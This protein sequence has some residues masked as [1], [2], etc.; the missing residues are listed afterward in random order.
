MMMRGVRTLVWVGCC[1][2]I[3]LGLVAGGAGARRLSVGPRGFRL[4]WTE[5]TYRGTLEIEEAQIPIQNVCR[6]TLSGEFAT[7]TFAKTTETVVAGFGPANFAWTCSETP[8]V[9]LFVTPWR[10]RY[11][12]F[13]GALPTLTGLTLALEGFDWSFEFL[14]GFLV[15]LY[16][17][18]AEAPGALRLVIR[19]GVV[20]G[21]TFPE[22][23]RMQRKS[24]AACP[25]QISVSGTASVAASSGGSVTVRLI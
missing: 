3:V 16:G 25:A 5:L 1:G 19:S 6:L 11:S 20:T 9:V 12:S 10:A 4:T 17:F 18:T 24:G 15:C 2:A 23:T 13:E 22:G 7:T 8:M 14:F 21:A